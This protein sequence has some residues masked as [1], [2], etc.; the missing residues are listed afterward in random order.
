MGSAENAFGVFSGEK[1]PETASTQKDGS[2]WYVARNALFLA[3]GRFY[4]RLVG[5]DE[6]TL[7]V[8]RLEHVRQAL[9]LGTAAGERPWSHALFADALKLGSD[10]VTY[11]RENAFSFGFAKG[12]SV[13]LLADGETEAFVMPAKDAASARALAKQFEDGFLSYGDRESKLG[14]TWIKD[15]YLN[16]YTRV[17]AE[18]AMV[19]GVRGAAQAET[20]AAAYEQLRAGVAALPAE[21]VARAASAPPPAGEKSYE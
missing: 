16:T 8:Q 17:G 9:V 21:V 20:A 4:A 12:V 1:P 7:V 3:R 19:V 13:G 6:S 18:G 5:S 10:R 15:R 2:Q 14:V 11:E